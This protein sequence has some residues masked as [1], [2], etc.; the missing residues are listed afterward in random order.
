MRKSTIAVPVKIFIQVILL[1]FYCFFV[2]TSESVAQSCT[3]SII[4]NTSSAP[5]IDGIIDPVWSKA[6]AT[7][8][9][10]NIVGNGSLQSDYSA[11]WKAM[12]DNTY[13]YIFVEVKDA[14]LTHDGGDPWQNDAVEIYIDGANNKANSYDAND[15]QIAFELAFPTLQPNLYGIGNRTGVLS[16]MPDVP[17]GYYLE[18][19]IPWTTIG[20][21]PVAGNNIGFDININDDDNGGDRDGTSGWFGTS[22]QLFNSPQ[23]FGTVPLTVCTLPLGITASHTNPNCANIADGSITV[24]GVNG[25]LPYSYSVD[26]SAYST[27][28]IFTGLAA[29][30]HTV[31]VRDG[32]QI[33][34][35]KDSTILLETS[36]N[37]T[38]RDDTTLCAGVSVTLLASGADNYSWSASPADASLTTPNIATPVVKPNVTTTY[39]VSASILGPNLLSNPA[40]EN[41]NVGF[42]TDYTYTTSSTFQSQSYSINANPE[43]Q[44]SFFTNCGDHTTGSGKMMV[45]DGATTA[46]AKL[47]SQTVPVVPNSNYIFTY[48]IQTVSDDA[49][50]DGH[51]AG[52]NTMI[53]GTAIGD[54][55]ISPTQGFPCGNWAKKTYTWNSGSATSAEISMYD[56]TTTPGGNDFAIDDLTFSTG[57]SF[58]ESV[59]VTVNQCIIPLGIT[60]SHLDE[61][62]AGAD[63]SITVNGE[64]GLA[65]Y[66]Y[67]INNG[68]FTTNNTF[69]NLSGGTYIISVMDAVTPTPN[70]KDTTIIVGAGA[71]ITIRQDTSICPGA[72]ATLSVSGGSNYSWTASPTDASLTTPTITNPVVSPAVTTVYT[73][74][75]G[76]PQSGNLLTNPAFENGNTGFT[77]QYA[78]TT[79][80]TFN[81]QTYSIGTN[82][83]SQNSFFTNC[84][85]HTSGT[86]RMMIV[87]GGTSATARLWSQT[88]TVVPN[89]TYTFSYWIQTVSADGDGDGHP[90]GID[91]KINGSSIGDIGL[92]PTM[93][94]PCGNW[95]KRSYTW[96]S[97]SATSAEIV[98]YDTT[99]TANGN[100][101]AIDDLLFS[102]GG[103]SISKTVTITVRSATA[104]PTTSPLKYCK[105][106]NAVPLTANGTGLLWYTQSSGGQ[107]NATAPIPSTGIAGVTTYYV[108]QTGAICG[109]SARSPL[110][111]TIADKSV[112]NAGKD[113]TVFLGQSVVLN[114]TSSIENST[115]S[116]SPIGSSNSSVQVS[117]QITTPYTLTVTT[118]Q[119]CISTDE[120]IVTIQQECPPLNPRNAFT[121]NNDGTWDKWY[122]GVPECTINIMVD[123]YNR[124]GS[125]VYHSSN[126][127]DGSWDGTYKGKPLPDGTYYYIIKA[128]SINNKRQF[129]KGNVTIIR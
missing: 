26:N 119:G 122:I 30:N 104:A 2:I 87:D 48:W 77:S 19:A 117:P 75:S 13:L 121:P 33:P 115:Y 88:I 21:V 99:T 15:A 96:N 95:V 52:I 32:G 46:T 129:F 58:S 111:V 107:G 62:C 89:N 120:I 44:N 118:D 24:N 79:G 78:F 41:G 109:E 40:F 67:T 61:T 29:G 101:F 56:T 74:T 98:L 17:G 27:N 16:A 35:Q 86:S 25:T 18:A 126:Y 72:S 110:V 47:W 73:V 1:F 106:D 45:V 112:A 57:C 84:G 8:I 100:D 12:Y 6:P 94:I 9:T 108:S 76:N 69:S 103:C 70:R 105:G 66:S 71:V 124:W 93:G 65:P 81:S 5:V 38:V 63:G 92:S 54:I 116:W 7:A 50:G 42:T 97:G 53:N 43:N 90:A 4:V 125:L 36:A 113:T 28:N 114:G 37:L 123:V 60:A 91:T 51:P 85:D 83:S 10:K 128:T 39:T 11:T 59:T 23:L 20:T 31:S 64:D 82:P 22:N 3:G 14:F 80:S 127:T 49:D 34:S 55:G 68:T 102:T